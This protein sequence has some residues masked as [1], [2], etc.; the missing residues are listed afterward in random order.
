MHGV[1]QGAKQ[2]ALEVM[3]LLYTFYMHLY[4]LLCLSLSTHTGV[5]SGGVWAQRRAAFSH[6]F[7]HSLAYTAASAVLM[8]SIN[9]L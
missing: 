4:V 9:R 3:L 8:Y 2:V 7:C 5:K 6:F 1:R